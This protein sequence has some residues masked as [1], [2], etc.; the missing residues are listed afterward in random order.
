MAVLPPPK[1]SHP[2]KEKRDRA[3]LNYR[4]EEAP[5]LLNFSILLAYSI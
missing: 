5:E 4:P 2:G 3:E 1:R